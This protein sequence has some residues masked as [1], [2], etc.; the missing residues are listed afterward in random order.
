MVKTRDTTH[1]RRV[2][3]GIKQTAGNTGEIGP[4][5]AELEAVAERLEEDHQIEPVEPLAVLG[6]IIK[7]WLSFDDREK[8]DALRDYYAGFA[9]QM[10]EAGHQ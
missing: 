8:G 9:N 3:E 2:W 1:A 6:S 4:M 10:I 5:L 7:F